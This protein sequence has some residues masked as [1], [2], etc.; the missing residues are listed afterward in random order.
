MAGVNRPPPLREGQ[1]VTNRSRD[2]GERQ[3]PTTVHTC[4][5]P[6]FGRLTDGCPRCDELKAGAAPVQWSPS[7]RERDRR[8]DELRAAEIR[9]HDCRTARCGIVCTFGQ[10]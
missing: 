5:G 2:I 8:D 6:V 10:W 3:S 7:R 9:A 4:G 1:S